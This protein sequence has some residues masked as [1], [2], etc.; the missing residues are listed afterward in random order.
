MSLIDPHLGPSPDAADGD[1]ARRITRKLAEITQILAATPDLT[2]VSQGIVDAAR[3]LL[4]SQYAALFDVDPRTRAMTVMALSG[5]PV[6]VL[7]PGFRFDEG[8]GA[9]GL[10]VRTQTAV[11]TADV[12]AD[13]RITFP[14]DV[15]R[16][17]TDAPYRAVLVTPLIAR[18]AVVGALAVCDRRNRGVQRGRRRARRR[19]LRPC[20][21]RLRNRAALRRERAPSPC[22]ARCARCSTRR[23]R[24]SRVR[25]RARLAATF[26][27]TGGL[28]DAR[29]LL[30]SQHT[31][32][33]SQAVSGS[34]V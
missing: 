25:L 18:G 22:S 28:M 3:E 13:P 8:T 20:G 23:P 24:L 2:A 17:L 16:L 1:R 10:A 33:H 15:R 4:G 26:A 30:R 12:L 19:L 7:M 31:I 21:G 14:G 27:R 6:G 34:G 5:S 29:D 9:V 11:V 32:V